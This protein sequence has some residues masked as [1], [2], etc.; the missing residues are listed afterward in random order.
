[1]KQTMIAFES[2][3]NIENSILCQNYHE[4]NSEPFGNIKDIENF[5][6]QLILA[7]FVTHTMQAIYVCTHLHAI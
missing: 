6:R 4:T 2:L 5:Y 1:M 7:S 3:D